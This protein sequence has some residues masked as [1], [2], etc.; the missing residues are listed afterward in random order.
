MRRDFFWGNEDL[1][2]PFHSKRLAEVEGLIGANRVGVYDYQGQAIAMIQIYPDGIRF[3]LFSGRNGPY[4]VYESAG[5][6]LACLS[7]VA[8][9]SSISSVDFGCSMPVWP[10]TWVIL[11]WPSMVA[12]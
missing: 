10:P 1:S 3:F 9:S 11:P 6:D 5:R 8:K 7:V 4:I 12:P 2:L